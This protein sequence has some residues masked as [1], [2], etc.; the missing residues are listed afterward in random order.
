MNASMHAGASLLYGISSPTVLTGHTMRLNKLK[1]N[2]GGIRACC[3][4]SHVKWQ[5]HLG[6]LYHNVRCLDVKNFQEDFRS[7]G[8]LV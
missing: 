4:F 7:R 6:P 8:D 3:L 2:P 1:K 5:E